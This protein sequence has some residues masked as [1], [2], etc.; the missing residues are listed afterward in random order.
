MSGAMLSKSHAVVAHALQVLDL[1]LVERSAA[2]GA[3][4]QGSVGGGTIA[5]RCETPDELITS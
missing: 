2:S 3:R 4:V 5:M 1:G